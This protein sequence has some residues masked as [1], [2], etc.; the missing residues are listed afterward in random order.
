[1]DD[2]AKI[3][4]EIEEKHKVNLDKTLTPQQLATGHFVRETLHGSLYW[5]SSLLE[6]SFLASICLA[7]TFQSTGFGLSYFPN[8]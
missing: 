6:D 2:S 5:V 4:R 3:I 7:L 8:V 1:M